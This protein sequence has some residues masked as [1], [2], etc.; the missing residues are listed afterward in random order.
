MM[1][2]CVARVAT[3]GSAGSQHAV[4]SAV[5]ETDPKAGPVHGS[6]KQSAVAAD[7]PLRLYQRARLAAGPSSFPTSETILHKLKPARYRR[8]PCHIV[9]IQYVTYVG[10]RRR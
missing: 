10:F 9:A 6:A 5:R 2:T 8:V 3:Q 7:S 4:T 1:L